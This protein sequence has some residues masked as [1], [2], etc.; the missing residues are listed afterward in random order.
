M[1]INDYKA[2]GFLLSARVTQA[3][4]DRAETDIQQAYITPLQ[5]T[6]PATNAALVDAKANLVYLLICQRSIVAT[7]AGAKVK[8]TDSSHIATS[9]ENVAEMAEVCKMKLEILK[10]VDG[11]NAQGKVVDL[12]KI[13]FST[14]FFKN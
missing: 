5:G 13:Y 1:T 12:C 14:N 2:K 6:L 11:A 10:A 9:E 4:V 7:R 3:V 8:L